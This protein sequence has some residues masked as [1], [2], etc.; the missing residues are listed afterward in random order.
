MPTNV[1]GT[2]VRIIV[3]R[4]HQILLVQSKRLRTS[5]AFELPGGKVEEHESYLD[6]A[7]RELREETGLELR[8]A[9]QLLLYDRKTPFGT[10][11]RYVV[12]EAEEYTGE[13]FINDPEEIILV[14]WFSKTNPPTLD[15][16]T[17]FFCQKF[18]V[19][20]LWRP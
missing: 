19:N 14:D 4:R 10:C 8:V 7:T 9:K 11:W 20:T 13:L 16:H 3:R 15:E 2:V 18:G 12:F 17:T 1:A 6:T 5:N